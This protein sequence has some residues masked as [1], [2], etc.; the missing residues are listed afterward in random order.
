MSRSRGLKSS[1]FALLVGILGLSAMQDAPAEGAVVLGAVSSFDDLTSEQ[2]KAYEFAIGSCGAQLLTFDEIAADPGAFDDVDVAWWH[3]DASTDLPEAANDATVLSQIQGFV[4]SGGG[5]LLTGFAP[6]Y[7][8]SLGYE[9]TPPS[10]VIQDPTTSGEWGFRQREPAHP[11]F[12]GL[13]ETFLV[14]SSNL[15]VDNNIVWWNDPTRFD[16]RWLADTEWSGYLVTVG[17]YTLEQ[18]RILL[19][20]TGAF[21][22]DHPGENLHRDNLELFTANILDYLTTPLPTPTPSLTPTPTPQPGEDIVLAD[23]EWS[24]WNGWSATGTAWGG[25]PSTGAPASNFLGGSYASS[26]YGGDGATGVLT[27]P[28]FLINRDYLKFLTSG[29]SYLEASGYGGQTRVNL[30][31][32]GEVAKYAAGSS[33]TNRMDWLEWDLRDLQGATAQ[34]QLT[35]TATGPWGHLNIDHIVLSNSPLNDLFAIDRK[36]LNIPVRLDRP[37]R[38]VDLLIDGL[39]VEEFKINLGTPTDHDFYAFIEMSAHMGERALLRVDAT[40]VQDVSQFPLRDEIITDTPIYEE[41]L[42]PRY[43]Y[44]ARRGFMND[45]N[46]MVHFNGEYHLSYQHNPFQLRVGNQV[47]GHA[48][49]TNLVHWLELPTAING[50]ALG[51]IWSGSAVVDT[52]NT[53]GLGEDAIVSFY[54]NAAGYGNN[55]IMSAGQNFTQSFAYSLDRNRTH[56]KYRNNPVLLNQPPGDNRDPY[57]F[58]YEPDQKWIMLLWLR[59]N[60]STFA[61]FSSLDLIEWTKTSEFIFDGVIEVPMLFQLPLDGDETD[62]RWILWA[63]DGHYYIGQF[64]GESF[65]PANGPFWMPGA[66]DSNFI[67]AASQIFSNMPDGRKILM[68]N[69]NSARDFPGM[70][71]N[72]MLTFP[73]EL[74]LRTDPSGSP[75]IYANPVEEIAELIEETREWTNVPLGGSNAIPNTWGEAYMIDASFE[76]G[77]ASSLTFDLGTAEVTYNIS[78]RTLSCTPDGAHTSSRHMDG[79]TPLGDSL[80]LQILVD[81]GSVEIFG[82]DGHRYMTIA[83][84]P[85][86]G[87]QSLSLTAQGS[88]AV[89]K[90][91][92]LHKLGSCWER[93]PEPPAIRGEGLFLY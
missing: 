7:V 50:D 8:L 4:E 73:V 13:P 1:L 81:V 9:D 42:R 77:S 16:G 40:N 23:F 62:M 35:D 56:I 90:Q 75:W 30:L 41:P 80:R 78:T 43:H 53:S 59:N 92:F 83:V 29:G 24:H 36:Y 20:G 55:N 37:E 48:V 72:K 2:L 26:S 5:L 87:E 64:N 3:E 27:S 57:V 61:Y 38:V 15:T 85:R 89:L 70:P 88:G 63:G 44:T 86:A 67:M 19:V 49:S 14:L 66:T 10:L 25:A 34:I 33:Q 17:E 58:W 46:G 68:A 54:T 31:I 28:P 76:W 32:D 12:N 18:G 74:S 93:T 45:T 6:Q 47:W 84:P 11:I 79:S 21:E 52:A 91:M 39:A 51:Q 71:F 82:N 69:D 65:T 22:W 60:P